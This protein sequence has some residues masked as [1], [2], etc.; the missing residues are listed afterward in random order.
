MPETKDGKPVLDDKGEAVPKKFPK[1]IKDRIYKDTQTIRD[2]FKKTFEA[3]LGPIDFETGIYSRMSDTVLKRATKL[4]KENPEAPIRIVENSDGTFGI[5]QAILPDQLAGSPIIERQAKVE[6]RGKPVGY[7]SQFIREGVKKAK[8]S[9]Y[10]R[11]KE[12]DAGR[13]QKKPTEL[14]TLTAKGGKPVAVNLPDLIRAGQR[15]LVAEDKRKFEEGG[16]VTAQ[17]EGLFRIF[18]ELIDRGYDIKVGN[19]S[20][21]ANTLGIL[22]DQKTLFDQIAKDKRIYNAALK[23]YNEEGGEKPK[24]SDLLE[25]MEVEVAA[26][27]DAKPKPKGKGKKK[28]KNHVPLSQLILVTPPN[29]TPPTPKFTVEINRDADKGPGGIFR[30]ILIGPMFF[31]GTKSEVAAFIE[32]ESSKNPD[33]TFKIQNDSGTPLVEGNAETVLDTQDESNKFMQSINEDNVFLDM[34]TEQ[35]FANE[36]SETDNMSDPDQRFDKPED[37]VFG[38]GATYT[39]PVR[40][41]FSI[42]ANTLAGKILNISKNALKLQNPVSV[43]TVEGLV[44]ATPESLRDMFKDPNVAKYM[45]ER[46]KALSENDKSGATYIGFENAHLIILDEASS[47]NELQTALSLG[48]ELGHALFNEQI[49]NGFNSP[50]LNTRLYKEYQDAAKAEGAPESYQGPRG[51]EEWYSDQ[52]SLW[53]QEQYKKDF[54]GR[55]KRETIIFKPEK[56]G[57]GPDGQRP[58]KASSKGLTK[59]HFEKIVAK[60]KG[61]FDALSSEFQ[62]RFG[63]EAYNETFNEYIE[64]VLKRTESVTQETSAAQTASFKAKKLA[65]AIDEATQKEYGPGV[66]NAIQRQVKRLIQS[67]KLDP[68]FNFLGTAD[69]RMR[70][71]G[72]NKLADIFYGRAQD[73]T[74]GLPNRLGFVKAV[75]IQGNKQWNKLEKLVGDMQSEETLNAFD[76]AFSDTKTADLSPLAQKVRKFFSDLHDDYIAPSNTDIQKREDYTPVVLNM[77]ELNNNPQKLV[78]LIVEKEGEASRS[79]AQQAVDRLVKFQQA[80]IDGDPV[81]VKQ[82]D[83]AKKIEEARKL[84]ANLDPKDLREAGLTLEPLAATAQYIRHVVKRVEWN[85]HT[86]AIDG[87]NILEEELGKLNRRQREEAE[88]IIN[89]YLGYNFKPLGPVWKNINSA[90]S[91]IQI[92]GILPLAVAGSIPELAGPVIASKEF[93]SMQTGI[94]EIV[95]TVKDREAARQLARDIG[96]VSNQSAAN[97]L[98]SQSELEWMNAGTRKATDAFFRVILLDTY[99]KFTREFAVNMGIKFMEQHSNSETQVPESA[100]YLKELG[101]KPEQFKAWQDSGM[102]FSTPEGQAIEQGLQRFVESSTLRPNAAERPV[103][104]SDPRYALVWQLKGFFYSYGKVLLAGT[105]REAEN[106]AREAGLGQ[107]DMKPLAV[108]GAAASSFALMGIATMPLAMAGMELREYAKY[109]LAFALPGFSPDDKDYFRTDSMTWPEYF[110]AAFSRSF[111]HGPITVGHQ[112]SQALDWGKGPLGA[113]AVA[114]GPT[115][116]TVTRIFTDGFDSTF[117]NRILPTGLL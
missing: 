20:I 24:R 58:K 91:F 35:D 100:R 113:A 56:V 117:R 107:A 67:K 21:N 7:I 87:A 50:T 116:E 34:D 69:S 57:A 93:G 10:A 98:M 75:D 114:A 6:S 38:L 112:M 71:I 72:G 101:I 96:I 105:K 94:R 45:V 4:Q 37:G 51:F 104:A 65:S 59:A 39:G 48:H 2:N 19:L 32:Q 92:V 49:K 16:K 90:L 52:V 18:S 95:N 77:M 1:R 40:T 108:M 46:A 115:A 76:E 44:N 68:I 106:R 80:V 55:A 102:D 5:E 60:L 53:A 9:V 17:R 85:R 15:I 36:G 73:S 28:P 70:R 63:P 61:L 31:E 111:A 89:T 29:T 109:G 74:S 25:L 64:N 88:M 23:K 66:T 62:R 14:F 97:T 43:F 13:V 81:E 33:Y 83:P 42:K 26:F 47:K 82:P 84:T 27:T 8:E 12:T 110:K 99:T 79:G 3:T 41:P 54:K 11:F 103:W 78:E 86:K 22:G 30:E